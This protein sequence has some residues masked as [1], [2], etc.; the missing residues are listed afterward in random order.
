MEYAPTGCAALDELF[1]GGVET[2]CLTL[3]YGEAGSGKTNVC[4]Q[5]ARNV[6]RDEKRAVYIDTEGVSLERLKQMCGDD[7]QTVLSRV[8][9]SEPYSNE[10]QEKLIGQAVKMVDASTDIGLIVVDSVTM[11]YRLTLRDDDP[12]E[13]RSLARQVA[14]LLRVSRKSEIPVILTSQVYTDIDKGTI[15][16]LGGHMLAHNCKTL[17]RFEKV[18][19]ALRRAVRVKHRHLEE[20]HAVKFRLTERGVEDV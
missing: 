14:R 12:E 2:G 8:L 16:P 9:F 17:V 10:E 20:G 13:R 1:G 7:Y 4:L 11:H 18:G 19:P 5:V 15:E 3:L 6:A